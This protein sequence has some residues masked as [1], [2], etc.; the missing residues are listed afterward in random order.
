MYF[1]SVSVNTKASVIVPSIRATNET[2]HFTI[3]NSFAE[4]GQ[5]YTG[6]DMSALQ[7]PSLLKLRHLRLFLL[8]SA[9]NESR[10]PRVASHCSSLSFTS[11]MAALVLARIGV[12]LNTYLHV[13]VLSMNVWAIISTGTPPVRVAC[14][15]LP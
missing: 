5:S 13:A 10:V 11:S 1:D 9:M 7:S 12:L 14:S 3:Y 6:P 8:S 4:S 15:P 2:I